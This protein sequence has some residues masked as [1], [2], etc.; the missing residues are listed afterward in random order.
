MDSDSEKNKD[1]ES[2]RRGPR[3]T[4][5]AKQL[6]I[7][8]NVFN[9]TPKP[10][11][12][13]RE[14]LAK[15]TGLP[16]RVIQVWF[17]NKRSK[18]KRL[19]QMRFMARGPFLPPNARRGGGPPIGHHGGPPGPRPPGFMP[20]PPTGPPFDFPGSHPPGGSFDGGYHH[21][22]S[23]GNFLPPGG[24]YPPSSGMDMTS[25]EN[26]AGY[27]DQGHL[28]RES[29]NSSCSG[30]GG[31]PLHAFPSPPPQT[32]DFSS[33]DFPSS[34]N[35]GGNGVGGSSS[36]EV[37]A[38]PAGTEQCYPS[39]PLSLEYSSSPA[40]ATSTTTSTVT[41]TMTPLQAAMV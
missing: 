21:D 23:S 13:M 39:P 11:R 34:D 7:L 27:H 3:T 2:K 16:M 6:E 40:A 14:Q 4:I 9:Q 1:K 30:N 5:K 18:E 38:V 24:P 28:G 15:E 19:H 10:T 25:L 36:S 26:M 31:N 33:S 17:Q 35:T 22:F 12:L 20:F 29:P 41:S 32:Q 8:R 37:G